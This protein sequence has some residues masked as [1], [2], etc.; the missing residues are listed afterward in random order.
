MAIAIGGSARDHRHTM[1]GPCVLR[2]QAILR[3][4]LNRKSVAVL[5]IPANP[6][7]RASSRTSTP[8]MLSARL[9]K[10]ISR[11]KSVKA[12]NVS[13]IATTM[14]ASQV[15][16]WTARR[17]NNYLPISVLARSIRWSSTRSI[18]SPGPWPT[19]PRSSRCSMHTR[20]HS[21][22]SPSSSIP[23]HRWAD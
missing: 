4:L 19:S 20:R 1:V 15:A 2:S 16:P 13:E 7:T 5:S 3:W 18:V 10:P 9:V 21:S 12:G 17:W 6:P 23:P 14:V 11:A 22:R 8:S